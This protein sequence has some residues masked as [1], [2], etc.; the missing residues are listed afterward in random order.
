[1]ARNVWPRF[2]YT[3]LILLLTMHPRELQISEFDYFLPEER[4]PAHPL[5]QRDNAKLLVFNQGNIHHGRFFQ[6]KDF[7]EK[8]TLL[9]GNDTRVIPARLFFKKNS[10]AAIEIFCLEPLIKS[11]QDAMAE[12]G[13]STWTCMIGGAKK[14]KGDEILTSVFTIHGTVWT[15]F[16]K[17]KERSGDKFVIEF[18]WENQDI[19]FS[20]VLDAAGELPLPPYFQRKATEEDYQRYQTV[21]ALKKG[22][23]AAPTAGLHFTTE[24]IAELSTEGIQKKDLTLHV[25]AGTFKPVS[26]ETMDGHAMHGEKFS[27]AVELLHYL[28]EIHRG[29]II[30]IGTT[31]TRAL[32]SVYWLGIKWM[33]G[34][35]TSHFIS[36]WEAYDNPTDI[37]YREVFQ[38]ICNRARQNEIQEIHCETAIMMAPGYEFRVID[39]LITNFHMPKSTLLLL[40][41]AVTGRN[42]QSG[43]YYWRSIY[44]QALQNDYRFLSYGDS[45]LLFV[46]SPA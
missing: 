5:P 42:D 8:N 9:I 26:T 33:K 18:S 20:E 36:Q 28:A 35:T 3:P 17:K 30:T 7:L 19:R 29:P 32:E 1:M 43:E 46:K 12:Q 40:V 39:G 11:H 24:L 16:A 37:E 22:S 14:W 34:Q 31:T 25:G 13:S 4:I 44:E 45:S 2:F 27:I 15:V 23:V 10:G 38:F 21:F 41:A 6:L